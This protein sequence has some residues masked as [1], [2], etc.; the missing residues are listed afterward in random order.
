MADSEERMIK[1]TKEAFQYLHLN[2]ELMN[3]TK[4]NQLISDIF[5]EIKDKDI[6]KLAYKPKG[7]VILHNAQNTE[8]YQEED[9]YTSALLWIKIVKENFCGDE[10]SIILFSPIQNKF[11]HEYSRILLGYNSN[12]KIS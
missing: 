4:A 7:I 12:G 6:K 1:T 3:N 11:I 10:I 2:Q 9:A 8:Q 5:K